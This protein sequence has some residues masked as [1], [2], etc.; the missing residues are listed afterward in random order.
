MREVRCPACHSA[1]VDEVW[2]GLYVCRVCDEYFSADESFGRDLVKMISKT[3]KMVMDKRK[4]SDEKPSS[5]IGRAPEMLAL[6]RSGRLVS[7]APEL[8]KLIKLFF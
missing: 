3:T 5:S 6:F 4:K 7:K 1:S 8:A 2:P